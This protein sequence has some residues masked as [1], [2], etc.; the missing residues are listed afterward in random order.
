MD[1]VNPGSLILSGAMMLDYMGWKEAAGLIRESIQR[2]I[3]AKTVTYDLA[4]QINGAK[5]IACSAL[6][7]ALVDN[8]TP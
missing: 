4:R 6:G 2:T 8:M 5:E 7:R 1:K 3:Q